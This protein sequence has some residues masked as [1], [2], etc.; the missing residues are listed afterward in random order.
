M[1]MIMIMMWIADD[2]TY[3]NDDDYDD[4]YDDSD[5]YQT[6][7]CRE[8]ETDAGAESSDSGCLLFLFEIRFILFC[9]SRCR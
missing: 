7:V 5:N 2:V 3:D 4:D 6:A 8:L 9:S 1:I